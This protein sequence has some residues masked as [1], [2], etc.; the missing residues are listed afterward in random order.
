MRTD[1]LYLYNIRVYVLNLS[2][3]N[4]FRLM[5]MLRFTADKCFKPIGKS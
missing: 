2:G 4:V 5:F 1:L 3:L